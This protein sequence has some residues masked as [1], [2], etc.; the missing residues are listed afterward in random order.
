MQKLT[1]PK[2]VYLRIGKCINPTF[3]FKPLFTII[4]SFFLLGYTASAQIS[5]TSRW[6]EVF[7]HTDLVPAATGLNDP[8][9]IAYGPDDSLWITEAKGYRVLHM[10]P[11]SGAYTVVLDITNGSTFLPVGYRGF[12][13][14][15]PST[16]NPWPQGGM[17]G[18]AIHPSFKSG[19]PYV[20]IAYVYKYNSTAPSNGGVFFTNRLVRFTDSAGMLTSPVSL[21]DT[22]P[23]SSDH[24]SGRIIIAP[25]GGVDYLFYAQGDMGAGQFG[26]TNRTEKAQIIN[27]YEGKILRF[28]LEPDGDAGAY[29]KWIPN[30]NPFNTGPVLNPTTQ[31]AV[32][33][34]GIRNN[35][36]FAY[37][38]IGGTGFLYGASHGPLV[39]T[40]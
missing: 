24:N 34:S 11:N 39:M 26:N 14:Q 12:N 6:N 28:N 27:S 9:E 29:N 19:K 35:Q 18:L 32:W 16:Q 31:S 23:G 40:K 1:V 8:W 10:D 38:N 20:Y 36:G 3:P 25:V 5:V 30:D 33:V 21:C 15:F 13:R 4:V 37:A 7:Q 17:M 2:K 22:L